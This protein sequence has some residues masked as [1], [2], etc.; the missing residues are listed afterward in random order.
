VI[1]TV[2]EALG[3][4]SAAK[5]LTKERHSGSRRTSTATA[6][7]SSSTPALGLRRHRVEAPRLGL[8]SGRV[9]HWCS[10]TGLAKQPVANFATGWADGNL[11]FGFAFANL[12]R[13]DRQV[14][15]RSKTVSTAV[16][17]S[18]GST[19]TAATWNAVRIAVGRRWGARISTLT[20]RA[21][22]YGTADGPCEADCERLGFF[23]NGDRSLPDLNRLFA[24]C[25]WSPE[26]QRARGVREGPARSG[27]QCRLARQ[28]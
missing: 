12:G 18:A 14:R 1:T 28:F 27:L 26:R 20:I 4:R 11:V 7:S 16:P 5:L 13:G 8:R 25:R 19:R 24:E 21:V 22:R 3:R 15:A 17:V 6:R 10:D 2:E 23:V 9:D